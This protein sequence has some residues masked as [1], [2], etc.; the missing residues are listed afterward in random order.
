MM[1]SG[2]SSLVQDESPSRLAARIVNVDSNSHIIQ[3]HNSDLQNSLYFCS[4]GFDVPPIDLLMP[5]SASIFFI[6]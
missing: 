1:I 4:S 3:S 5:V 2:M 6:R